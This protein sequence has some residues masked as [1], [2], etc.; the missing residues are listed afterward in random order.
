V[1]QGMTARIMGRPQSVN[2]H[3]RGSAQ[4]ALWLYGWGRRTWPKLE[5]ASDHSGDPRRNV[6]RETHPGRG[7]ARAG[8]RREY[9]ARE[10]DVLRL[11]HGWL[12]TREIADILGRYPQSVTARMHRLGLSRETGDG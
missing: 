1:L 10:D 12:Q 8:L 4:R 3:L 6:P 9:T 2:P 11:C 5:A 7:R